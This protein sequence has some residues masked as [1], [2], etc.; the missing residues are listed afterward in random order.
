MSDLAMLPRHRRYICVLAFLLAPVASGRNAE[1]LNYQA[2]RTD[3]LPD[4]VLAKG[5]R[6]AQPTPSPIDRFLTLIARL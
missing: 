4:P 3:R 2:R 6:M 1:V 5:A